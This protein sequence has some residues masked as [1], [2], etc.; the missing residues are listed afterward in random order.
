M[1]NVWSFITSVPPWV[2]VAAGWL[3]STVV[4]YWIGRKQSI[5]K[6][7]LQK[8][9]DLAEEMAVLLHQDYRDRVHLRQMYAAN[10]SHLPTIPQATD[11]FDKFQ[12][13]YVPEKQLMGELPVG[14]GKLQQLNT[15]LNILHRQDH[16]LHRFVY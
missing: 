5:D 2:I 14:I 10:F 15:S 11:A 9:H 16:P 3:A 7:Q 13:L 6:I 12:T 4:T 8:R 1:A